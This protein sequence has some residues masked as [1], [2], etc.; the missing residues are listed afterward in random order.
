MREIFYS[1]LFLTAFTECKTLRQSETDSSG[2]NFTEKTESGFHN[3]QGLRNAILIKASFI[4][5]PPSPQKDEQGNF[6]DNL[7]SLQR[8]INRMPDMATL[9]LPDGNYY[10]S[11]TL[12]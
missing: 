10:F 6:I 3:S 1:I 9:Y 11:G 7:D 8:I 2:N 12:K 5:S 4:Y